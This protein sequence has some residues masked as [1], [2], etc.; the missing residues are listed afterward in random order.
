MTQTVAVPLWIVILGGLLAVWALYASL[1]VP[2]VRW[3]FRRRANRLIEELNQRLDLKIPPIALTRRRVMIDRLV[4]DPQVIQEVDD[5]CESEGVPRDVAVAKVRHYAKEMVPA[6]NAYIYFRFGSWLSKRIVELLYRVRLGYVDEDGL[7]GIDPNASVVF[8]MNHRSNMDYILVTYLALHRVALS[9]AVGEWA[10]VWPL[11][12]LIRALGAYFVRRGSGNRLYRRVL[13]R[14]VQIAIEGG[15]TQ[16]VFPE[17]GLTRD[18]SLREPRIGLLDYMLRKFDPEGERDIVFVP[19]GLNYD[20]VLEDRTMLATDVDGERKSGLAVTVTTI[21]F[22]GRNL[23][24]RVRRKLYRFGYACANFG[25]P[26]SMREYT[27][28]RGWNPRRES[29]EARTEKVA[30]FAQDLMEKVRM[31]VPVLPVSLVSAI[32]LSRD[33]WVD[34]GTIKSLVKESLD[35]LG[36]A[37]ALIYL[38]REDPEYFVTVGLRMLMLRHLVEAESGRYRVAPA[39]RRL[40]SYYANAL[41]VA[42]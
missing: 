27:R 31:L 6:F 1:L 36:R 21:K 11:Q 30:V 22:L 7:K 13:E 40:L 17:G 29:R 18:G 19:V 8:I 2:G 42:I 20:R 25:T 5:F 24:L 32:L 4:Y 28:A 26:V 34:E 15:S 10:R 39:E 14:Y 37:G 3:F 35:E 16:A 23:W 33:D 41:P 12:Q 9:Y 38:P